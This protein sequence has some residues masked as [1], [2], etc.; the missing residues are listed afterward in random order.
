MLAPLAQLR[1]GPPNRFGTYRT[2]IRGTALSFTKI[3]YIAVVY[4]AYINMNL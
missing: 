2:A 4:A 1:H 3:Y